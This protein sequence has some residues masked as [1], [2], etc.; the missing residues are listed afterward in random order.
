MTFWY[1]VELY[2]RDIE[3]GK[4]VLS[5]TY[6]IKTR[7]E[8][9]RFLDAVTGSRYIWSLDIRSI[10]PSGEGPDLAFHCDSPS[11]YVLCTLSQTGPGYVRKEY[12]EVDDDEIE[13]WLEFSVQEAE[14][15]DEIHRIEHEISLLREQRKKV[16]A[17]RE[18]NSRK[19]FLAIRKYLV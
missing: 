10:A 2:Q 15:G 6:V 3:T 5:K 14:Y 16:V 17:E 18:M 1:S 13:S 9:G 4:D 7:K 8:L 19:R 12:K 11:Q